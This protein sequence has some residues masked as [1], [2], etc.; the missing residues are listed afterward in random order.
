MASTLVASFVPLA[1]GGWTS[2]EPSSLQA[3]GVLLQV[4]LPT[5]ATGPLLSPLALFSSCKV[6]CYIRLPGA[7]RRDFRGGSDGKRLPA[8]DLGST[9]G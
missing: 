2:L 6:D 1:A 7:I 3:L 9:P 8:G 4:A 5:S